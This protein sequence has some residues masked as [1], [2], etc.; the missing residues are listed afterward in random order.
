MISIILPTFNNQDSI[1]DT[2]ISVINQSYQLWELIIVDDG[3]TDDTLAIIN[4]FAKNDSRINVIY[5]QHGG[6]ARARNTGLDNINGDYIAFIDA[7]DKFDTFFLEK[8]IKELR[9][10]NADL[11]VFDFYR[12]KKDQKYI[13]KVGTNLFDSYGACWNKLYKSG[14]WKDVRFPEQ[15]TIEDMEVVIPIVGRAKKVIKID[16]TYYFYIDRKDSITNTPSLE[17]EI[18]VKRALDILNKNLLKFKVDYNYEKYAKFVNTFVYWHMISVVN[19]IDNY[20]EKKDITNFINSC[21]IKYKHKIIFKGS[22]KSNIKKRFVVF[23]IKIH[24]FKQIKLFE[25]FITQ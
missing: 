2:I 15:M 7:D 12:V 23:L 5:S 3:S 10:K 4:N 14:L 25:N 24:A 18:Q 6:A 20:K 9:K 22:R 21:F 17:S 11:A 1:T 19:S 8:G 13:E 16:K